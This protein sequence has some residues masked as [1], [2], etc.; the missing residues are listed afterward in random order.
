MAPDLPVDPTGASPAR[1]R[2]KSQVGKRD[3]PGGRTGG[4]STS[5]AGANGASR[6]KKRRCKSE[7]IV[8]SG[9]EARDRRCS[10][11]GQ[12][13]ETDDTELLQPAS[14]LINCSVSEIRIEGLVANLLFSCF[15]RN[16][17]TGIQPSLPPRYCRAAPSCRA[18]GPSSVAAR[19]PTGVCRAALAR[20]LSQAK[21]RRAPEAVEVLRTA[22]NLFREATGVVRRVRP[23]C[24][25]YPM[26]LPALCPHARRPFLERAL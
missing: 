4:R 25:L 1:D 12:S 24:S 21:W 26:L 10:F 11:D 2:E 16:V 7:P 9:R 3:A 22:G 5:S 15:L 14:N 13:G 19:T 18:S 23:A 8:G 6:R 20:A 17:G